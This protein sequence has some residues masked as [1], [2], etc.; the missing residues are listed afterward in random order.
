MSFDFT[1]F[2]RSL[3]S[4]ETQLK[5]LRT[6]IEQLQRKRL[7]LQSAPI[8]KDEVKALLSQWVLDAGSAYSRDLTESIQQVARN[9]T[10]FANHGRLRQLTSFGAQASLQGADVGP[11]M[12]QAICAFF[13]QQIR[14]SLSTAIDSMEWPEGAISS[15]QRRKDIESIGAEINKLQIEENEIITKAAEAGI[16]LG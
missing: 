4:L 13:G 11:Q 16:R 10:A 15:E 3:Q 1:S 8:S 12:G 2:R 9:T 7:A 6:K 14:E 5:T